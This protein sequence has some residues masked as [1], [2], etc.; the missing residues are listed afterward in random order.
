MMLAKPV[1]TTLQQVERSQVLIHQQF[2]SSFFVQKCLAKLFLYLQFGFVIFWQKNIGA[3]AASKMLVKLTTGLIYTSPIFAKE[4]RKN[5][6]FI[7]KTL[8]RHSLNVVKN[9]LK[10]KTNLKFDYFGFILVSCKI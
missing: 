8:P 10:F 1:T 9:N 4:I 7:F 2:I 6:I 5:N 3:K